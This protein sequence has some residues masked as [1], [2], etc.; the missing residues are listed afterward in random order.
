M[1]DY[2]TLQGEI[3]I[4]AIADTH[5]FHRQVTIL[6]REVLIVAGDLTSYGT[7]DNIEEF[8][9]WLLEQPC[10]YKIVVAGNHDKPFEVEN[11]LAQKIFTR[12]KT[13][14]YF[15]P[16]YFMVR[17]GINYYSAK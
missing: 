4:I 6:A 8:S 10:Q 5:G 1:D 9:A 12:G 14:L 7:L 17:C 13:D 2:K 15:H 11:D 3:K 16:C